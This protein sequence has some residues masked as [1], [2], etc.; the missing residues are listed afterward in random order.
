[1][2]IKLNVRSLH[3]RSVR[4]CNSSDHSII[5]Q[6]HFNAIP[7]DAFLPPGQRADQD[8]DIA[9]RKKNLNAPLILCPHGI[10]FI[11][12]ALLLQK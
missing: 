5:L 1:M 10:F 12:H 2:V 11:M 3:L 6:S 8:R 4:N 9:M 7:Y